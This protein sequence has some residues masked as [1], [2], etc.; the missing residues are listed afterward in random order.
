LYHESTFLELHKELA[1]K[2]KHSTAKEAADIAQKAGVKKLMLG[3][4]SNRYSDKND[5]IKEASV[6]F[7]NVIL[8]EDLKS[9]SV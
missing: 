9:F 3:H 7:E 2:T 8:S 1:K 6:I 4:Y 5:F